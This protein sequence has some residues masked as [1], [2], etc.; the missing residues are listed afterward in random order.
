MKYKIIIFILDTIRKISAI[1]KLRIGLMLTSIVMSIALVSPYIFNS[2][3][4][5]MFNKNNYSNA[6]TIW[7]TASIISLQNKD[8]M[9][10]NLG[11]TLYRQSQPELAVEKYEKAINYA[12]GDMICKIKW[13]LAVVLTSLGDGKEF[14]A[15][16]EAISYYSRALLQLSDEECLKNP[17]Y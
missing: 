6:K 2:L 11:N 4:I 8:V 12:S 10:A 13:N 15:P 17:E 16:T 14:G 5:I 7:Q 1:T 3:A 9:L